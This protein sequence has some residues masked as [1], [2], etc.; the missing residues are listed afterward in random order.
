MTISLITQTKI[1]II[2]TI[3]RRMDAIRK[4]MQSLKAET[5]QLYSTIRRYED[6]TKE[7]SARA[8]Q[9]LTIYSCTAPSGGTRMLPR[10]TQ[11]GLTRY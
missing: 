5:E 2:F 10:S 8:D 3:F 11:L 9:V 1:K 4:K 7:Y 6:A